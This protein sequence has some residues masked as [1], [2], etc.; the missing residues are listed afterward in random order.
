[1]VLDTRPNPSY[2]PSPEFLEKL[3]VGKDGTEYDLGPHLVT[4]V[5]RG[6]NYA[7]YKSPKWA[8]WGITIH[9]RGRN[10]VVVDET[11]G[12]SYQLSWDF[13]E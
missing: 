7:L 1:M 11:V 3:V 2:N 6:P 4:C 10:G 12:S 5:E 13:A 9:V 8:D